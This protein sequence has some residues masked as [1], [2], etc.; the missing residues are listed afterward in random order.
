MRQ[1]AISLGIGGRRRG[2]GP[3]AAIRAMFA[4]GVPGDAWIPT[5]E[6]CY[7]RSSGGVYEKVTTSGDLVAR[8]IGMANGIYAEQTT[9]S[10]KPKYMEGGGLTWLSHDGLD[11]YLVTPAI[12]LTT[13][14]KVGVFAG[15]RKLSDA[16]TGVVVEVGNNKAGGCYIYTRGDFP[17]GARTLG[18]GLKQTLTLERWGSE[19]GAAPLSLVSTTLFDFAMEASLDEVKFRKN[20]VVDPGTVNP[21]APGPAGAGN[22]GNYPLYIGRRGGTTLPFNG[23]IYG[24]IALGKLPSASEITSTEAYLNQL[25]AAYRKGKK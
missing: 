21:S 24:L 8:H 9:D 20:G 6:W 11:D 7:T 13:T 16:A 1:I 10:F 3:E 22:F 17:A 2:G 12:G 4:G 23:R 14:D 5:R 18:Y 15:V 25:T 19:Y